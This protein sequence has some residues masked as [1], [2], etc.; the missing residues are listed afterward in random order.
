MT[1]YICILC[2]V[3]CCVFWSA[4][5]FG[6]GFF[7][8]TFGY[9]FIFGLKNLCWLPFGLLVRVKFNTTFFGHLALSFDISAKRTLW[10]EIDTPFFRCFFIVFEWKITEKTYKQK[11]KMSNKWPS[12][13]SWSKYTSVNISHCKLNY[14]QFI[15]KSCIPRTSFLLTF[16]HCNFNS[17]WVTVTAS[18]QL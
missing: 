15:G 9:F 10:Y 18:H 6:F 1:S 3:N 12:P 8:S 2:K 4:F 13:K 16:R 14:H 7:L 5:R 17:I 11:L